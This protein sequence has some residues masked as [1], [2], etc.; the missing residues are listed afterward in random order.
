MEGLSFKDCTSDGLQQTL[1]AEL[2]KSQAEISSALRN[3]ENQNYGY[4]RKDCNTI[5][6]RNS[7]LLAVAN[8]MID[9]NK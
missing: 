6:S 1:I 4:A 9:R 2:A 7:L 8:E 3:L 5:K